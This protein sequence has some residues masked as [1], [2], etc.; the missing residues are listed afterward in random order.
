MSTFPEFEVLAVVENGLEAVEFCERHEVDVALLD[1]QM[2]HMDGVE[3]TKLLTER[4]KTK[5]LI[6]TTFDDESFILYNVEFICD[7]R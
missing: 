7:L 3:A 6:L 5:T 4:T 1:I 2:P